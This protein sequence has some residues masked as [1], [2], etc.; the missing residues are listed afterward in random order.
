MSLSLESTC[1]LS[2]IEMPRL[3]H[4]RV[5]ATVNTFKTLTVCITNQPKLRILRAVLVHPER[6]TLW[7]IYAVFLY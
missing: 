3:Q 7:E 1:F 5:C 6:A 2:R 4:Y